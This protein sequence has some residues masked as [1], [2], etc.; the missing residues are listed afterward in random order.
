MLNGS[1]YSLC[2]RPMVNGVASGRTTACCSTASSGTKP[3]GPPG[4]TC[5][6]ASV[7]GKPST[8]A[9]AVGPAL[10]SGSGSWNICRCNAKPMDAS[11]GTCSSSTAPSSAPTRPRP[12]LEKKRP[13]GEPADHALGRSQ[14]GFSTKVHLVCDGQGLPIAVEIGPGQEHE[15]QH[16]T[17]LVQ[18]VAVAQRQR[19][20]RRRPAKLVGD[21]GYSAGWIR[22]WL[23]QHGITP[24]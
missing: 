15:T 14:G 24:V 9:S 4:A 10:A 2:S 22:R 1:K 20:G 16:L 13:T 7:P 18:A 23:R 3:P 12:G 5:P 6:N 19:S 17:A 11:T 8:A 21:K